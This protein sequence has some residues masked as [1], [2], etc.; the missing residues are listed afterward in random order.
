MAVVEETAQQAFDRGVLSG[1]ITARLAN[2][3]AHFVV[4]NGHLAEL[5]VEIRNIKMSMQRIEDAGDARVLDSAST[6]EALA[7]VRFEKRART[8]QIYFL[9]GIFGVL[10][11]VALSAFS[12]YLT[13]KQ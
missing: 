4:L 5:V 9:I 13:A 8:E 7:T 2:H 1:E 12:I 11:A 3:D 10:L 6:T